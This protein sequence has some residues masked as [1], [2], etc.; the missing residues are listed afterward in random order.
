MGDVKFD[1]TKMM[2]RKDQ[3]VEQL[4]GGITG[5]FKHNGVDH[6]FGKGKLLKGKQ[7][8]FTPDDGSAVQVLDA[9]NVILATGSVPVE[10]PPAPLTEGMIVDSTGA[11]EFDSV[12]KRL[13]VIGGGVIGLELAL[14]GVVWVRTWWYL[15]PWISSWRWL[16]SRSQRIGQDPRSKASIFVLARWCWRKDQR[17]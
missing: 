6:L 16:I 10:I 2:A 17:R 5:L 12:P 7:V 1:V 13:G 8:E 11:L 4:T 14:F 3:I 9:D 15:K